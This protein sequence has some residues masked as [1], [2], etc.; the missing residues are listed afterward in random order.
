MKRSLTKLAGGSLTYG[1]G[2]M[3]QRFLGL[4]LLPFYTRALTPA[5]YGIMALLS[6]ISTA[7]VSLF[8][9]GTGNSMGILYFRE[10]VPEKR[11]SIIWTTAT[12]LVVNCSILTAVA[13]LASPALSRLLFETP[14]HAP[15]V[16][17][18]FFSLL[19]TSVLEPFYAYLRMEERA[20]TYVILTIVDSL[21]TI[22][23]SIYLVLGLHWGVRGLLLAGVF[24]KAVMA[25]AVWLVIARRLPFDLQRTLVRPLIRIGAP[26]VFG[27]FAF[28]V[29]DFADRQMIQRM[30]GLD[31][32]GV[33]AVGYSFGMVMLLAVGAFGSAWPPFFMSFIRKQEEARSVFGRVLT[34]YL[35]AFGGLTVLF[36]VTAKPLVFLLV[37]PAFRQAYTLV[38]LV[39]AAYMLKGCYLIL[40]P[41][42]YYAEKLHFQSGIEWAAAVLN[43]GLNLVLIPVWG[44]L[45]PAVATLASYLCLCVLAWLVN[46]RFLPVDYEWNRVLPIVFTVTVASVGVFFLTPTNSLLAQMSLGFLVLFSFG[47]FSF[48]RLLLPQERQ[49]ALRR[50]RRLLGFAYQDLP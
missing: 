21:L 41:G 34:Y 11:P 28:M 38:P 1:L 46:R 24:A 27:L 39:A 43:V 17:L 30:L 29:I 22:V 5:D 25:L 23:A 42:V 32:L 15:L 50:S 18:A 2:S 36:A 35:L 33:Y 31:A 45:G 6:L 4:F 10:S 13:W 37:A 16:R 44:I 14:D 19:I 26:G 12:L 40:L 49:I 20:T 8:T 47:V 48:F 9:L 7:A 3:L